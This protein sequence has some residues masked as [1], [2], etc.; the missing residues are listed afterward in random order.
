M[1]GL[2]PLPDGTAVRVVVVAAVGDQHAGPTAAA[3]DVTAHRWHAVEQVDE[4]RDVVAVAAGERPTASPSSTPP[5]ILAA[6]TEGVRYGGAGP[7]IQ[8]GV[9]G[10]GGRTGGHRA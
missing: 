3:T 8:L 9:L 7:F 10:P 5:R 1:I 2:T 6:D 4:L